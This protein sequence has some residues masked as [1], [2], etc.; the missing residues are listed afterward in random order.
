[1]KTTLKFRA[2]S[3]RAKWI[4]YPT[5]ALVLI[6]FF[7]FIGASLYLGGDALNGYMKAGQYFLCAHG[8][9]A[10]VSSSIWHYSY[11]HAW[12]ALSGI[13]LIFA[14]TAVFLNTGDIEF[15]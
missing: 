12:T 1:V 5:S 10:Q 2:Y 13:L 4:L 3:K 7:A 9:C 6:N 15:E 14:E 11:W 8:H